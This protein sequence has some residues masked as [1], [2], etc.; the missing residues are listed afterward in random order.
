[1]GTLSFKTLKEMLERKY[2]DGTVIPKNLP[3][4]YTPAKSEKKCSNCEYYVPATKNCKYWKAKVK[5]TYWCAKWEP[6]EKD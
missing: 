3:P 4:K 6:I 2:P 5:P 1:M